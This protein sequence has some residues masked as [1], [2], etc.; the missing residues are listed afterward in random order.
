MARQLQEELNRQQQFDTNDESYVRPKTPEFIKTLNTYSY[1]ASDSVHRDADDAM[2]QGRN[3]S[4]SGEED[5]E[6][7][8][9]EMARRIYER[10]LAYAQRNQGAS[11]GDVGEL[12]GGVDPHGLNPASLTTED[13]DA[14][15]ARRIYERDLA[16]AQRNQG[17]VDQ[18]GGEVDPHG[19]GSAASNST[20]DDTE[21]ARRIYERDL[22][23][24]KRN[25]GIDPGSVDQLGSDVDPHGFSAAASSTAQSD[26]ELA[27]VIYD[28]DLASAR[29][30]LGDGE[31][32]ASG[33]AVAS[34]HAARE[35]SD[36]EFARMLQGR[37]FEYSQRNLGSNVDNVSS[38]SREK[39]DAEYA[40]MLYEQ[41]LKYFKGGADDAR[42][43]H[44]Q[45]LTYTQRNKN[46][47][48]STSRSQ[49]YHQ[50]DNDYNPKG[51][52]ASSS[53]RHSSSHERKPNGVSYGSPN[54][55]ARIAQALQEADMERVE[56]INADKELAWKLQAQEQV[57][58]DGSSYGRMSPTSYPRQAEDGWDQDM[59]NLQNHDEEQIPARWKAGVVEHDEPLPKTPPTPKE[60]NDQVIP[61]QYCKKLCSFQ[62]LWDH[63]VCRLFGLCNTSIVHE[64]YTLI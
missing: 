23:Y 49:S 61:C 40:K 15:M 7:K 8:D 12:G 41:D 32:E 34:S 58:R 50:Q 6:Q 30:N 53:S 4:S 42:K 44:E 51:A 19:F 10:D 21:M 47:N 35:Q 37:D 2:A 1:G 48:S 54:N 27:K 52:A 55:D 18:L 9:A 11:N 33:T 28:R 59:I 46:H 63:E 36:A 62:G 64:E 31:H 16:Y 56:T 20:N 13:S 17:N 14:K 38:A 5:M 26:A 43:F 25:Q 24:A 57:S 45:D 39:S 29:R 3:G 60:E 22:A